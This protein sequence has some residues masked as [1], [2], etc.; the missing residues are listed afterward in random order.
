MGPQDDSCS[1]LRWSA[2]PQPPAGLAGSTGGSR[3]AAAVLP[4]P[5]VRATG[6]EAEVQR[7]QTGSGSLESVGHIQQ[8][9]LWALLPLLYQLSQPAEFLQQ[10]SLQIP[11]STCA[12]LVWV[13]GNKMAQLVLNNKRQCVVFGICCGCFLFSMSLSTGRDV[14]CWCSL[15]HSLGQ[16]A[17]SMTKKPFN[18]DVL[19]Y[20][21]H[22]LFS[23]AHIK[24]LY[25]KW[26]QEEAQVSRLGMTVFTAE[27]TK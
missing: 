22:A 8:V 27:H 16:P 14:C 11:H 24:V 4:N 1:W 7:R 18:I 6:G 9:P 23:I 3:A 19:S 12:F 10:E 15:I 13:C 2:I 17:A 26:P 20:Q 5:S 25:I 21:V